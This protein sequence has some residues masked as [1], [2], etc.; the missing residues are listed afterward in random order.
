MRMWIWS[1]FDFIRWTW[2]GLKPKPNINHIISKYIYL[3]WFGYGFKKNMNLTI[4][5]MLHGSWIDPVHGT[6]SSMWDVSL[7]ESGTRRRESGSRV[8]SRIS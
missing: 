8:E 7:D 2:F 5:P 4:F 3:V 1:R 6:S